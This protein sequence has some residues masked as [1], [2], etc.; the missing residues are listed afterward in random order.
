MT[1]TQGVGPSDPIADVLI[2]RP[3]YSFLFSEQ[4]TQTFIDSLHEFCS[5]VCLLDLGGFK[6]ALHV[7]WV[8]TCK[9]ITLN[10][11]LYS[12]LNFSFPQLVDQSSQCGVTQGLW[13]LKLC[14]AYQQSTC[15][16][17]PPRNSAI[18]PPPVLE[19]AFLH[20]L[21]RLLDDRLETWQTGES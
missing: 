15:R 18:A 2:S 7:F 3:S 9:F 20:S 19:P 10:D 8:F 4:T 5:F 21:A 13:Q 12:F 17:A 6:I 14:I 16:L 11:I 1:A